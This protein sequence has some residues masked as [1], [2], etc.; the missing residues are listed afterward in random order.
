MKNKLLFVLS[1]S[2]VAAGC[3]RDGIL[4]IP[5]CEKYSQTITACNNPKNDPQVTINTNSLIFAP[6]NV[7][8]A[9]GSTI[10]FTVVPPPQNKVGSVAI[11]PKNPADLWLIG[12]NSPDKGKI[13]IT[14]PE[15][16][17]LNTDHDYGFVTIDGGC[18]DPRVHV[19]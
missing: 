1:L 16:V 17:A 15:W 14:V 13:E 5:Q 19:E 7:C 10:V 9:P 2:V 4:A 11:I 6:P 18:V 12:T 3:A 8:A